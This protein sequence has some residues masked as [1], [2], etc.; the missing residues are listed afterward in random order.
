MMLR[1]WRG[2]STEMKACKVPQQTTHQKTIIILMSYICIYEI[3]SSQNKKEY[4]S[5]KK[6]KGG[7]YFIFIS[8]K[9]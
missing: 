2:V 1:L 8:K 5:C 6:A 9:Y 7:R 3:N 4:F